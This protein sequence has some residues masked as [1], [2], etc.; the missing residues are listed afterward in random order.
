MKKILS[1]LSITFFLVAMILPFN[2]AHAYSGGLLNGKTFYLTNDASGYITTNARAMITDNDESTAQA[3]TTNWLWAPMNGE[4]LTNFRVSYNKDITVNFLDV[5]GSSLYSITLPTNSIKVT[6]DITVNV[7]GVYKVVID[8]V[9]AAGMNLYEFDAFGA[10][11]TPTPTPTPAP[12]PTPTPV[13][14]TTPPAIPTG[15]TA[16]GGNASMTLKWT[17][18]T[19]PDI[20]GYNV[21]QDGVK[22][23]GSPITGTNYT[24]TSLTNA[25]AYSYKISSVDTSGNQSGQSAAVIGTPINTTP[26][27]APKNIGAASGNSSVTITWQANTEPD[28]KGYNV[29]QDGV[30]V[31]GSPITGTSYVIASGVTNGVTYTYTV[32]AVNTSGYESVK[33]TSV[34]EMPRNLTPP[35][36]PTGFKGT[37]GNKQAMLQWTANAETDIKGYNLYNGA[38]KVNGSPITGTNYTVT[39]LNNMQSYTFTLEAVNTSNIQSTAG[40]TT[41]VTP[42]NATPP[43]IPSGLTATAGNTQ[44]F[45]DWVAN[46]ETDLKGYN[47]YYNATKLNGSPITGKKYTVSSLTNGTSYSFTIKAV[48]TSGYESNNSA[49]AAAIPV[50]PPAIP[51]GLEATA[52]DSKVS[53]RWIANT[54]TNLKGYFIYQDGVKLNSTPY[55]ITSFDVA[56]GLTNGVTYSFAIQS[57]DDGGYES[58]ISAAVTAT[59][60]DT[61]PPA[62]PTGLK[63]SGVNSAADLRWDPNTESDL[64]GYNIYQNGTKVNGSPITA[65]NYTVSS[66]TN[67]AAYSFSITS[68]DL[69]GNES[70]QSAAASVTPVNVPSPTGLKAKPTITE[71]TL[72]WDPPAQPTTYIIYRDG[73]QVATAADPQYVDTDVI[74]GKHY[75]YDVVA[76]D[77]SNKQSDKANVTA[78][79]SKNATDYEKNNAAAVFSPKDLIKVTQDFLLPFAGFILLIAILIFSKPLSNLGIKMIKF[80]K[81]RFEDEDPDLMKDK[82]KRPERV[83]IERAKVDKI[84]RVKTER[85][86]EVKPT[87]KG[88]FNWAVFF[89]TEKPAKRQRKGRSRKQIALSQSRIKEK[90]LKAEIRE[91][92]R[93]LKKEIREKERI[94]AKNEKFY[95]D[96]LHEHVMR[97]RREADGKPEPAAAKRSRINRPTFS[98]TPRPKRS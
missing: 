4:R 48:N 68:I 53:L 57:I 9:G 39:G 46:S 55:R 77:E 18:N 81:I 78:Y 45:L 62:I 74:S 88:G 49:A 23:N 26:P 29:Y 95:N 8:A 35:A 16:T 6:S 92:D 56:A 80:L 7:T 51:S 25:K 3:L 28:I 2:T 63:G 31:N 94:R 96:K 58:A 43:A 22:L 54:E 41:Q 87:E 10:M 65:T 14:D 42:I 47:V 91:K 67:G 52:G 17:A 20:R 86:N 97:R 66:L 75:S 36:I 72:S 71:V 98:S 82:V 85:V 50:P 44:I 32:T 30:K 11:P 38:T 40:A 1:I 37:A 93:L 21:Y 5:N 12:T 90:A 69:L 89:G 79:F 34:N 13:P 27:A 59:P 19:E 70:A 24:A 61:T 83:K 76:V 15:L 60:R 33:S 64:Q 84:E 73:V